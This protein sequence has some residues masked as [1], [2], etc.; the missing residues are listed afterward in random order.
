L[1][2]P[3]ELGQFTSWVFSERVRQMGLVLSTGTVGDAFDNALVESFSVRPLTELLNRK[4]RKTRIEL[5]TALFAYL[6]VFHN[7]VTSS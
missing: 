2:R 6:E 4:K 7:H 1:R 5:S 3:A